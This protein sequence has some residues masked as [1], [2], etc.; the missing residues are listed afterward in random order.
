M[1]CSLKSN[2]IYAAARAAANTMLAGRVLVFGHRGASAYAP[3]NTLPAFELAVAQGA[4]GIELDA[5]RT[6]DG[7]VVIIHDFTVDKTTDGAGRVTDM[8]LAQ[9]RELDAGGWFDPAFRGI[10]VPTLDEVFDVV[11]KKL[12]VNVEIKSESIETD[13]VEQAVADVIARYGMQARVIVSSFNPLALVRFRQIMPEVP[14]GMLYDET[15]SE[16]QVVLVQTDLV[17]EAIHPHHIQIDGHL[18]AQARSQGWHVNT[19]TVNDPRRAMEL[20][21]LGVNVLMTD[22]PDRIRQALLAE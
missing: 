12:F 6:R 14:L 19:W 15:M 20:R 9:V 3:M 11:G 16:P 5:H 2:D 7:H 4:D 18:M 17:C 1:R 8:T 22:Y 13:G 10:R 21:D